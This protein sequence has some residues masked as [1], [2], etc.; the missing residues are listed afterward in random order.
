MI[1]SLVPVLARQCE[2]SSGHLFP[3][4]PVTDQVGKR[5]TRVGAGKCGNTDQI[6]G[7]TR[8]AVE[9]TSSIFTLHTAGR[10]LQELKTITS[11]IQ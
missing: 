7:L 11:K 5:P 1:Y 3:H 2:G 4:D 10:H 8:A 6:T 9:R